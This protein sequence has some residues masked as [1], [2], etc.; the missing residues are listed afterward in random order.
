MDQIAQICVQAAPWLA[1]LAMG[2][3]LLLLLRRYFWLSPPQLPEDTAMSRGALWG[4]VALWFAL[5]RLVMLAGI[6][7]GAAV[8]GSL[9]ELLSAPWSHWIRWDGPHYIGLA[10]N[11]YVTEGDPRFHIVFYPLYPAL[12]KAVRV[13][14]FG[15]TQLAACAVSNVCF[16]AAG[17]ALTEAVRLRQGDRAALRALRLMML[18]PYSVFCSTAY[19][20]SLF[21]M[22]CALCVLEARKERFGWAILF[23]ALAANTRM[24][25][26]L[27]AIPIFYEML[28][29]ARRDQL[30]AKYIAASA[31][32]VCLVLAGVGAY[33]ALNWAV[34]GDPFRF[35]TYQREHWG[36]RLGLFWDTFR[37]TVENAFWYGSEPWRLYT[38]IPQA[39]CM[40]LAFGLIA[41]ASPRRAY[42]ADGAFMWVYLAVALG[43]TWLL[44][45]PR[46]LCGMYALYP[47]LAA[48]FPRKWTHIPL[49]A[50]FA[51]LLAYLS[52]V[53]AVAGWLL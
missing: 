38:W 5:S 43:T 47:I 4:R 44:S 45:G 52:Y 19:T 30:G 9:Q 24:P 35:M 23:G 28:R 2:V 37:Y 18:S 42:P 12:V 41:F 49:L 32:Q 22:L 1:A 21:L 8:K 39:I 10:E 25:G 7:V 6:F 29:K 14:F 50:A 34:T 31:A 26:V 16:L 13:L 40:A 51:L 17:W 53:Y 3:S 36:Q 15:H 11:W 27:T 48:S 46:Y 33:I 20:E